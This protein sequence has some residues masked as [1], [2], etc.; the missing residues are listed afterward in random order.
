MVVVEFFLQFHRYV[1]MLS[2]LLCS[3]DLLIDLYLFGWQDTTGLCWRLKIW[4][5]SWNGCQSLDGVLSLKK[6]LLLKVALGQ[7]L[8]PAD[9]TKIIM[10]IS[11]SNDL[12]E[13]LCQ[14]KSFP[15]VRCIGTSYTMF[16][17]LLISV[18]IVYNKM[19]SKQRHLQFPHKCRSDVLQEVTTG[20]MKRI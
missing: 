18:V 19:C 4:L 14:K 9:A 6:D 3:L 11:W 17:R 20:L 5:R 15:F 1:I 8:T 13:E 16:W 7:S 10:S 2:T 12:C